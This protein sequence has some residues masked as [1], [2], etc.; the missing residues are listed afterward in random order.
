MAP[1]GR[2]RDEIVGTLLAR[3]LA[4]R[5]A[6]F[7]VVST[8]GANEG[9]A[10]FLRKASQFADA[11]TVDITLPDVL[12][13]PPAQL[14][15]EDAKLFVLSGVNE[16]AEH[17]REKIRGGS[18]GSDF[19]KLCIRT[20]TDIIA[21]HEGLKLVCGS[22]G[23]DPSLAQLERQIGRLKA[24]VAQVIWQVSHGH[25]TDFSH[26]QDVIS[27]DADFYVSVIQDASGYKSA[28]AA[29]AGAA[30]ALA[31]LSALRPRVAY[32]AIA[33]EPGPLS[34]LPLAPRIAEPIAPSAPAAPTAFAT[35]FDRPE[36]A[37]ATR[38]SITDERI[39]LVHALQDDPA[40]APLYPA[41]GS[42][43]QGA[44]YM[45]GQAFD[46]AHAYFEEA[47]AA[48]EGLDGPNAAELARRTRVMLA[49]TRGRRGDMAGAEAML[50][51]VLAENVGAMTEYRRLAE[52]LLMK[53][54][55]RALE[56]LL[57][58]NAQ[59][60][61]ASGTD[62]VLIAYLELTLGRLAQAEVRCLQGL[63]RFAG[64]GEFWLTLVNIARSRGSDVQAQLFLRSYFKS[65][66]LLAPEI[67]LAS[68]R[69]IGTLACPGATSYEGGPLVSVVMTS[70]NAADTI[71]YAAA[72]I[73]DQTHRNL[74]L[75]IVDD[76]SQDDSVA[77]A[78]RLAD[79][80]PRVR[81]MI[82]PQNGG[83]YVAKNLG[84]AASA[85][86]FV[87]LH[88]SDDWAH[89]QRIERQLARMTSGVAC[90]VSNWFRQ[91]DE[92]YA[93]LSRWTFGYTHRN[94]ASTLFGRDVIERV[95]YFDSVRVGA[96]A[97]FLT[98]V[99]LT[100]GAA[101]ISSLEEPLG[102]GLHHGRSLTQDGENGFDENRYSP[103]RS[104]YA[105]KALGWQIERVLGR[106]TLAV[107]VRVDERHFEVP[108]SMNP[109]L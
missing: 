6:A 19:R 39:R 85:G 91:N 10:A 78:Q 26:Y 20:L 54:P 95:G 108:P 70:F 109:F 27:H 61:D 53:D 57:A 36:F 62:L 12:L 35:I 38:G 79:R 3:R 21:C 13:D 46:R 41:I 59:R 65:F 73:L 55:E 1:V 15:S 84:I 23:G 43:A 52:L 74:E 89:P 37:N 81:L 40:F 76:H 58:C 32:R 82:T 50:Y 49:R 86:D 16:I 24:D 56:L 47:L 75:I 102:V 11:L 67:D 92:G 31:P 72:S 48:C 63:R 97:E 60:P 42:F 68:Q 28:S 18:G 94:P 80:D 96:D 69:P 83:T 5:L 4:T 64:N 87:T 17:Y 22:G 7:D 66:G 93:L 14:A 90:C 100:F 44:L 34:R 30:A 9:F 104:A 8:V 98:R 99:R 107:P 2:S 29:V 106:Q 25:Q 101:A 103:V 105:E 71:D 45:S 33:A 88:D 51:E 77:A